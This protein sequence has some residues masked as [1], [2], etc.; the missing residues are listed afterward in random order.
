MPAVHGRGISGGCPMRIEQLQYLVAIAESGSFTIAGERLFVAQ[1]SISQSIVALEKELDVTLLKR[2]R[3]GA[4]PTEVGRKI[5]EHARAVLAEIDMIT[6]V[7]KQQKEWVNSNIAVAVAP[8]VNTT[9]MP[10]ALSGI[11]K[12]A[13]KS[14]VNIVEGV[15]SMAEHLLAKG[16]VD[17]GVVPFVECDKINAIFWFEP[18]LE[19]QLMAVVGKDSPL[20]KHKTLTFKE[21]QEH[22][23]MLFNS[24]YISFSH[25]MSRISKYGEPNIILKAQNP[26][27][28]KKTAKDVQSI[29]LIYDMGLI[30]NPSVEAG[31]LIPL[32]I[33]DSVCLTFGI[34]AKRKKEL[35]VLAKNMIRELTKAAEQLK[36]KRDSFYNRLTY[37]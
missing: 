21:I 18:L 16:E 11:A 34:L 4:E 9:I 8:L 14:S 2:T 13:A 1:P 5:I 24:E 22:P 30:A 25:V 36:E 35:S 15:T 23:I 6:K 3:Q 27:V 29:S 33:Q 20:A 28:I 32:P 19:S 7:A 31:E 37:L 17:F 10:T 12:N 26:E